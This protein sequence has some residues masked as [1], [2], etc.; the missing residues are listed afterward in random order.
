MSEWSQALSGHP[1][2]AGE[3][4]TIETISGNRGLQIEEKLIFEQDS[5]SH[6][7]VDF[8]DTPPFQTRLGGL[9]RTAPIV[10][11][12][13]ARGILAGVPLSRFYP[14]RADLADLLL[15]AATETVTADDIDRFTVGLA[16][17]LR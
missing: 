5:P 8:P 4:A 11:M 10:D 14:D 16:E 7:G 2:V 1:V 17:V 3:S 12:L 13:A 6:C 15:V 9:D